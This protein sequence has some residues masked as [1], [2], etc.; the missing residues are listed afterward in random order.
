MFSILP[1][2]F[3]FFLIFFRF[4]SFLCV[5]HFSPGAL[6][7]TF[8]FSYNNLDFEARFWVREEERRKKKER[9]KEEE[10]EGRK[11]EERRKK[12]KEERRT[13]RPKQVPHA[14]ELF[15]IRVRGKPLHSDRDIGRSC[16][17]KRDR[18]LNPEYDSFAAANALA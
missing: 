3:F 14:Q 13:R 18:D 7:K 17:E 4:V 12:K 8:I 9:K 10:E 1:F 2:F 16:D 11:K 15:V 5:F 6:P